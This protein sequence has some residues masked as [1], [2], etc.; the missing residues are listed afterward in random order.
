M[1]I[2]SVPVIMIGFGVAVGIEE[3][4]PGLNQLK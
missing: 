4:V 1:S 2:V 3:I